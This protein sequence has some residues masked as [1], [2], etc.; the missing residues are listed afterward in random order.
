M[1]QPATSLVIFHR[2]YSTV[3]FSSSERNWRQPTTSDV[4]FTFSTNAITRANT[5]RRCIH[6]PFEAFLYARIYTRDRIVRLHSFYSSRC[7]GDLENRSRVFF[8]PAKTNLPRPRFQRNCIPSDECTLDRRNFVGARVFSLRLF[9]RR[10]LATPRGKVAV[11]S[12]EPWISTRGRWT[13][14]VCFIRLVYECF[15]I[16][17]RLF[18]SLDLRRHSGGSFHNTR[19]IAIRVSRFCFLKKN[20]NEDFSVLFFKLSTFL[21]T[22][23]LPLTRESRE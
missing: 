10:C 22:F 1:S 11:Y 17:F 18:D 13:R 5:W 4:A 3:N 15:R 9:V 6:N 19:Y 7:H 20:R 14:A 12:F 8:Q 23:R 21:S 16:F 2:K